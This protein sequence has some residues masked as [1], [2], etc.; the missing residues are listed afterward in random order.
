[1]NAIDSYLY[2]QNYQ[3]HTRQEAK[4]GKCGRGFAYSR[5]E[6]EM[7]PLMFLGGYSAHEIAARFGRSRSAI[8][9]FC[10][11]HGIRVRELRRRAQKHAG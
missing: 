4:R 1:M 8:F 6:R 2:G 5:R 10:N 11:Y 7:I 3:A 9:S